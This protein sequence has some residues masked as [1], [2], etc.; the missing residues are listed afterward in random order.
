MANGKSW[1]DLEVRVR[2]AYITAIIA[3]LV[4]WGLTVAAFI[5]GAGVI[6]ESVLWVLGQS[7]AYAGS[8]LGFGMY[9]G[10]EVKNMRRSIKAFMNAEDRR[11]MEHFNDEDVEELDEE[12]EGEEKL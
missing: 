4:G 5:I 3:F 10:S 1:T 11:V 7:L 9:I 2:I 6:S 12:I 8:V